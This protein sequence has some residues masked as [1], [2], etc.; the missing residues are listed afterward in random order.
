MAVVGFQRGNCP[1]ALEVLCHVSQ[2]Q[3]ELQEKIELDQ[4]LLSCERQSSSTWRAPPTSRREIRA[5]LLC[6]RCDIYLR[7]GGRRGFSGAQRDGTDHCTHTATGAVPQ[8]DRTTP[9]AP[10]SV[11]FSATWSSLPPRLPA[12]HLRQVVVRLLFSTCYYTHLLTI[13]WRARLLHG[14]ITLFPHGGR[15]GSIFEPTSH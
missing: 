8:T 5:T 15:T 9:A 6:T 3:G 12:Y 4:D 10:D 14:F 2:V 7:A 11:I 1:P 13:E